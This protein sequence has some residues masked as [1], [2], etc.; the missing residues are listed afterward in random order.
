MATSAQAV[1]KPSKPSEYKSGLK[2][3]WC[4]GCGDFGVLNALSQVY[5]RL[6]LNPMNTML[7]SGIGC[8]SR[9]PGY[10]KSF[11]FNAVHGR[12]LPIASG[13]KLANPELTVIAAGGDGD[14]FSIGTGHFPHTCRRNVDITYIV[15]DNNIYGLT[16]GQL[17]PTSP[18]QMVTTTS[19]YGSIEYPI[20]PIGLAIGCGASFVARAFSG[21]IKHMVDV[22]CQG[23]EHK[24]FAFIQ[25]L[26][27]CVTFVGKDQFVIIKN[28]LNYLH[29]DEDYDPTERSHAFRVADETDRISLG[30]IFQHPMA[31][32][33]QSQEIIR[34]RLAERG[35]P[36]LR[37]L[38]SKFRP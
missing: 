27:P 34:K 11:G 21:D 35:L 20:N 37:D 26:S 25:I 1:Q 3:V 10:L 23:I 32:Y 30:V 19:S 2:P 15:M 18:G 4:P 22:I 31:E 8:S 33:R 6:E 5:H 12:A 29:E 16:K 7:F 14:G 17:S 28:Q 9:I 24:G 13:A 36:E 38:I